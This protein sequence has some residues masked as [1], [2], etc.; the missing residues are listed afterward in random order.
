MKWNKTNREFNGV[1]PYNFE[2][3]FTICLKASDGFDESNK[4]CIEFYS[5]N[6]DPIC[7]DLKIDHAIYALSP[8][9]F[10]VPKET[11]TD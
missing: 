7:K 5:E 2:G 11:C 4:S 6:E 10:S 3:N 9:N 1:V 8:W